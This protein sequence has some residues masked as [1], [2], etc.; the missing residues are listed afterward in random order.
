MVFTVRARNDPTQCHLK[1]NS[2]EKVTDDLYKIKLS[3][4]DEIGR[5]RLEGN[6]V[7]KD[8]GI[9]W[10]LTKDYDS[11]RQAGQTNGFENLFYEGSGGIAR[12]EG[13]WA[14]Y[15]HESNPDLSGT[16]FMVPA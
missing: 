5:S 6:L 12:M 10:K 15:G 11:K 1:V 9:A 2:I 8:D 13:K 16:W 4:T 7:F 3:G 14:Y